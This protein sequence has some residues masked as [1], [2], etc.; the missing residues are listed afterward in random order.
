MVV[1]VGGWG[2]GGEV[3]LGRNGAGVWVHTVDVHVM[4]IQLD[5][6][7]VHKVDVPV[8]FILIDSAGVHKVD[9]PVMSIQLD[10]AGV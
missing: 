3:T 10:G 6:A 2:G 4:S 7:G 5:G 9:V 1:G 8:M